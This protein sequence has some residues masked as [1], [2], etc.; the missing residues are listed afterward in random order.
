[1]RE[2]SLGD[3]RGAAARYAHRYCLGQQDLKHLRAAVR[4]QVWMVCTAVL[5]RAA[6]LV[7][8]PIPV[9][10]YDKRYS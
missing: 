7:V 9:D 10:A 8:V 4:F 5:F 2:N 6:S 1:M 3:L